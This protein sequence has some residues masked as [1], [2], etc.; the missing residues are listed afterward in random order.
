MKPI[1]AAALAAFMAAASIGASTMPASAGKNHGGG[2]HGGGHHGG[3]HHGGNH[4]GGHH[5]GHDWHRSGVFFHVAPIVVHPRRHGWSRH[6][7]WCLNHYA[8]YNP[9][10]NIY[11][12]SFGPRHCDSPYF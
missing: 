7:R 11:F 2:H 12:S 9:H 5:R 4:G 3:G 6:V 10:T 1:F 8:S